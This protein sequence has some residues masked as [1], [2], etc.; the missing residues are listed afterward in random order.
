[1]INRVLPSVGLETVNGQTSRP[2]INSA[3]SNMDVIW[4]QDHLYALS[5]KASVEIWDF[6]S[7][8]SSVPVKKMEIEPTFFETEADLKEL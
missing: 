7:S 3:S 6:S 2:R 8:A 1:M 4:C 5:H